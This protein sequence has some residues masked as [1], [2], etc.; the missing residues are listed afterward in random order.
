MRRRDISSSKLDY[1]R[2]LVLAVLE[3]GGFF[4]IGTEQSH[5]NFVGGSNH[6]C[7][8]PGNIHLTKARRTVMLA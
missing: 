3:C 6:R 1:V 2:L 8:A 5:V 4:A 7:Q